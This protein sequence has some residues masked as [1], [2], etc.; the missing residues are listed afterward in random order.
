MGPPLSRALLLQHPHAFGSSSRPESV[1]SFGSTLTDGHS[2]HSQE[3]HCAEMKADGEETAGAQLKE[4]TT[5]EVH[6]LLNGNSSSLSN[7]HVGS[8]AAVFQGCEVRQCPGTIY[9]T[10]HWSASIRTQAFRMAYSRQNG[11]SENFQHEYDD[12]RGRRRSP[13]RH[14]N[15]NDRRRSSSQ[16][17]YYGIIV[18]NALEVAVR[19][20]GAVVEVPIEETDAVVLTGA[21]TKVH[22][23]I[24]R[25]G[26]E[27]I[28]IHLAAV[29]EN[30]A[31]KAHP[32]SNDG[33]IERQARRSSSR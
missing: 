26:L 30:P 17:R 27:K 33:D 13:P 4:D 6:P 25:I 28:G 14:W 29:I 32:S 20:D 15:D 19:G 22:L 10:Y 12:R 2:V 31:V 16:E 24:N 18:A 9:D 23:V 11:Y 7:G 5:S 21:E 3:D 8:G 1:R